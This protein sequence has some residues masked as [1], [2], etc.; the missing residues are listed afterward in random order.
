M[1]SGILRASAFPTIGYAINAS[2]GG[3]MSLPVA[4]SA[5]IYSHFRHVSGVPAPEGT[6]GVAI[7]KLKIL[8]V[9]IEQLARIKK[10]PDTGL[11]ADAPSDEQIDVLIEHYESQIRTAQAANAAMPYKP[12]LPSSAGAVLNLVA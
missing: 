2:A 1:V 11:T 9:L 12:I 6:R 3:R 4:P 7:S 5:Y 10:N 8:D